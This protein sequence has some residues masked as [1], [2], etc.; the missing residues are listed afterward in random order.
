ML[1][2]GMG[3]KFGNNGAWHF[4][5]LAGCYVLSWYA[6]YLGVPLGGISSLRFLGIQWCEGLK[7]VRRMEHGLLFLVRTCYSY[8]IL[9][10]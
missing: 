1:K 5:E 7:K 4:A 3:I 6:I 8:A 2:H 10:F 9:S